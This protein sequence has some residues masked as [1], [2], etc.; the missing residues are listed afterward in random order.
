VRVLECGKYGRVLCVWE[1]FHANVC[2][3]ALQRAHYECLCECAYEKMFIAPYAW[4]ICVLCACVRVCVNALIFICM[5]HG[6]SLCVAQRVV[7]HKKRDGWAR[8]A[9]PGFARV[10]FIVEIL[11]RGLISTVD[12]ALYLHH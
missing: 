9:P 3:C 8:V 10:P 2:V 12:P 6:I 5:P 7:D 4:V 11:Q 1:C